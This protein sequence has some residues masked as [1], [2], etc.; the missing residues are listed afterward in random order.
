MRRATNAGLR[1]AKAPAG[2]ATVQTCSM[3]GVG[4]LSV[5]TGHVPNGVWMPSMAR[6]FFE[7]KEQKVVLSNLWIQALA[8]AS[9]GR[10]SSRIA[11][12]EGK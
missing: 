7:H 11:A 4:A 6:S 8:E 9:E 1:S 10:V 2:L 5:P 3:A 12:P